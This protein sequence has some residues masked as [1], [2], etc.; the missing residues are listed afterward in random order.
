LPSNIRKVEDTA[1]TPATAQSA[2]T[3]LGTYKSDD[4]FPSPLTLSI[5]GMDMAGNLSGTVGGMRTTEGLPGQDPSWE[6]WQRAFGREGMR[7]TYRAGRVLIQFPSGAYYD[8][9]VS[10]NMLTGTYAE[11]ANDTRHMTFIKAV[12]VAAR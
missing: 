12:G 3:V 11:T 7:A 6:R 4:F 9:Q 8:L 2:A 10:G 5:T 1:T